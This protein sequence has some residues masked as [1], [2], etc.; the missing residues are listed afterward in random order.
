M[1]NPDLRAGQA[2]VHAVSGTRGNSAWN[3][4]QLQ[5]KMIE[6]LLIAFTVMSAYPDLL[7]HVFCDHPSSA[8][9]QGQRLGLRFS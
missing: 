2:A 4:K 9:I 3:L 8:G 7:Y 1:E 5:E 6:W